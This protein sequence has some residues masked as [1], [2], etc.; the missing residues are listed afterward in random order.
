MDIDLISILGA[1]AGGF[2]GAAIGG[3]HAF[4][5]TGFMVLTGFAVLIGSGDAAF[6]G[7]VAFGPVFGPHIAFAGGVA[8][9]AYAGRRYGTNARDIALPLAS[10]A[11]PDVLLVGAGFGVLGYLIQKVVAI[12]PWFGANTDSVAFTVVISALIARLAFGKKGLFPKN[13]SGKSGWAAYEPTETGRWVEHQE[14]FG[15]L[16]A[17]GVFAGLL[18]AFASVTVLE[19]YP[20]VAGNAQVLMFGVSAVSL[21]FASAG[22]AMPVTHHITLP[23]G[24]AAVTF[25]PLVGEMTW[26]AVLIGAVVGL[27]GAWLGELFARISLSHGDTHIDPPAFAI[28]PATTLVLALGALV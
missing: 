8:A 6:L 24:L 26:L 18:A 16:T 9:V 2:F 13:D 25:L 28:F 11:K 1:A 14:R 19:A 23:A 3:L 10:L 17:L 5:F 27:I 22:H 7:D 4:I 21:A 12:I 15:P 20:Q